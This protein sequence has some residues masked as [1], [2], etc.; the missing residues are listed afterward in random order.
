LTEWVALITWVDEAAE[1]FYEAGGVYPNEPPCPWTKAGRELKVGEPVAVCPRCGQRFAAVDG[2][3]TMTP[4]SPFK[5]TAEQN[6][7]LHFDGDEDCPSICRNMPPRRLRL[8]EK[9]EA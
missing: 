1:M 9:G 6:R 5:R 8:I 7:D 2:E 4:V 3:G